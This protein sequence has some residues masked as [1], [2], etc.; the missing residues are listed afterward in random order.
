MDEDA[1]PGALIRR[2]WLV[3]A[4]LALLIRLPIALIAEDQWGDAHPP[5][6]SQALGCATGT[7]VELRSRVP[8]WAAPDTHRWRAG[9]PGV[10]P[11]L[12]ARLTVLVS[13]VAGVALMALLASRFGGRRAGL[14]AGLALALSPLHIQASTTFSSEAIYLAFALACVWRALDRD[15]WGCA[16]LA[17]CAATTRYD[18]WLWLPVLALWWIGRGFPQQ[19]ARGLLAAALLFVGPANILIANAFAL[20]KPFA[21]LSYIAR[22]HLTLAMAAQERM[23]VGL[24]RSLMTLFWP[25]ALVAVLTPGFAVVSLWS[26]GK[27]VG[28]RSPG[29]DAR[30][31]GDGPAADLHLQ[32]GRAGLVL[33]DGA[34][35]PGARAAMIMIGM[36]GIGR[37]ALAACVATSIAYSAVLSVIIGDGKPGLG[38][39][40]AAASP[41]SRLPSDLRRVR[42]RCGPSPVSWSSTI[43]RT[44]R[45]FWS[46]RARGWIATR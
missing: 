42:G 24:W 4:L 5:V 27:R 31:A 40:A 3:P 22:D 20:G 28:E 6:D 14:A 29:P 10:W 2:A 19:R 41:V 35:C 36:K 9:A 16:A 13:G 23:G 15:L 25:G 30:G 12:A 1:E 26:L 8:I 21:P 7:L 33:A 43:P 38:L 39:F 37:R 32:V 17:W 11:D 44:T 18:A 34:L 45:T 46:P